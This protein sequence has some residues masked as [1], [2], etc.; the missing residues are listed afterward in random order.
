[1]VFLEPFHQEK[2]KE[3][4]VK[5]A[6]NFFLS[7][8]I[9]PLLTDLILMANVFDLRNQIISYNSTLNESQS[10][11]K[12]IRKA[13]PYR[14]RRVVNI[15]IDGQNKKSSNNEISKPKKVEKNET[16]SKEVRV[17]EDKETTNSFETFD[18][19][20]YSED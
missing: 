17:T 20:Y 14:E 11:R 5:R 18:D 9:F 19:E 4:E 10:E 1:M 15:T 3:E 7:F 6:T 8:S 12:S 2:G 16:I 13:I